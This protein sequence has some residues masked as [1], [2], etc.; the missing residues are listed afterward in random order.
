MNIGICRISGELLAELLGYKGHRV[1]EARVDFDTG[2]ID[3]KMSG[4]DMPKVEEGD[5]IQYVAAREG[6]P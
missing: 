5:C 4:P 3:V 2:A 1:M 6:K